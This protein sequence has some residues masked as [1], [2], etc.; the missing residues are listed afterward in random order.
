[1]HII[2][3]QSILHCSDPVKKLDDVAFRDS[4]EVRKEGQPFRNGKGILT[5]RI[6]DL[7]SCIHRDRYISAADAATK[8]DGHD[9][10]HGRSRGTTAHRPWSID[11]DIFKY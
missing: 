4:V 2:L 6:N 10:S 3:I 11:D 5:T 8:Q 9:P 7:P 1:M